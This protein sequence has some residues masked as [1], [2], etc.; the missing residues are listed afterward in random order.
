MPRK[1]TKAEIAGKV[2]NR[3]ADGIHDVAGTLR[4]VEVPDTVHLKDVKD[5]DVH[6]FH[7]FPISSFCLHK[8]FQLNL[9]K[10]AASH[11]Y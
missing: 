4:D 3:F 5:W 1:E 8:N 2:V 11:M 7:L 6:V 10:T 9:Y